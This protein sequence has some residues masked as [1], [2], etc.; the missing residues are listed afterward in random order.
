MT[1]DRA[2]PLLAALGRDTGLDDLAYRSRP[3]SLGGGFWAEILT[4]TLAAAPAPFAGE[5]VAKLAPSRTHG[6]REATVQAEVAGQGFPVPPV[7][8]SG[9]GPGPDGWY[10]VMPKVQGTPPLSAPTPAALVRAVP[11]LALRLPN[12]LA[13]LSVRLHGLDFR[14]LKQELRSRPE[15]PADVDDLVTDISK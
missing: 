9:P 15:W 13:D 14:R 1:E 11:A 7:L 3:R 6:E 5:L 10:F 8:A 12:L 2:A 4:F